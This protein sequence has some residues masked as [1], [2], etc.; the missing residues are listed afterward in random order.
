MYYFALHFGA[1]PPIVVAVHSICQLAVD[2]TLAPAVAEVYSS[3]PQVHPLA[4][5]LAAVCSVLAAA[6][7]DVAV[8]AAAVLKNNLLA[9]RVH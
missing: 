7:G 1:L 9:E 8:A 4:R 2:A 6:D 5:A 3:L